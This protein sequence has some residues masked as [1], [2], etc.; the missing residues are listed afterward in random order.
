MVIV[1]D[2]AVLSLA[3]KR[4]AVTRAGAAGAAFA[5]RLREF[6]AEPML[7]PA[8]EIA[9]PDDSGLLDA[10]IAS[11]ERYDWVVFASAN[12][13]E[14]FVERLTARGKDLAALGC[15]RIGA[16][17][18]RTAA[19][20][21]EVGRAADFVARTHTGEALAAELPGVEG[22]RVLLP[23][24]DIARPAL[25]DGLRARRALVD[26]VVAYRTLLAAPE[27]GARLAAL[28]RD[29]ALDALTFTS[30]STVRGV[31]TMLNAAGLDVAALSAAASR[32]AIL[33]IGPTTAQAARD[34]GLPVDAVAGE[35]SGDG[36]VRALVGWFG[37]LTPAAAAGE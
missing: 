29:G 21:A 26:V 36:L 22:A 33:C 35:H 6:G 5:A 18:P 1:A 34:A 30:P 2:R 17:G 16:V 23:A 20:L 15:A 4:I 28:I 37:D 3:G 11:I 10:A 14:A 19:A 9:P 13:V 32:P 31:V 7:C 8:I 12:A 25:A 24:A 27:E